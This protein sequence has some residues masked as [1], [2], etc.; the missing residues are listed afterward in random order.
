MT[1]MWYSLPLF[2]SRS[3]RREK[4]R[5]K[6]NGNVSAENRF[7]RRQTVLLIF[8][9]VHPSLASKNN[10]T[11]LQ[12]THS[13][14]SLYIYSDPHAPDS[15]SYGLAYVALRLAY[16]NATSTRGCITK[17]LKKATSSIFKSV[18]VNMKWLYLL[19]KHLT[20]T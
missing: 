8:L 14:L 15:D 1:V 19:L 13:A 20:M 6:L 10:V 16:L 17:L 18:P 12:T 5:K 4:K 9:L 7:R 3:P 11:K 2:S